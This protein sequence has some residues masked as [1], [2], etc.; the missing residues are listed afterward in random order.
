MAFV[1]ARVLVAT[2]VAPAELRRETLQ[3]FD[4]YAGL[5]E[6]RRDTERGDT[7]LWIDRVSGERRADLVRRLR[8]GEV[9]VERLETFDRGKRID[10]PSGMVHHWIA[11]AF[12]SGV[13]LANAVAMAQDY[14]HHA[15]IFQPAVNRSRLLR[16]HGD[17]FEVYFRFV[18]KH[19]ITV[20]LDV[21]SEAHFATVDPSRVEARVYGNRIVEIENAGT[22]D[23][24][25]GEP[26]DG[27][28][29]LWRL[30]TYCRFH[31]RDG[32][33]YI[34]FESL[35]LTRDLPIGVGWIIRPF[36]TRVPRESLV[37]T[38]ETYV[39]RLGRRE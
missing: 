24:R 15:E 21:Q 19:V 31:Q 7:F 16:R 22:S 11:T 13:A 33:V 4:R 28:G 17:T 18:Q 39:K 5:T 30:N 9:A 38:L 20:V 34:E 36:V 14:D 35:S 32:G 27:H 25:A 6:A 3:S 8:R 29:F 10:I 23:E 37:F 26:D 12:I 1:I 2:D